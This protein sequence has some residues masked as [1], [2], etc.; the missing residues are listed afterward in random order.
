MNLILLADQDFIA[1]GR[2]R[3][4][5]DRFKQ[6]RDVHGSAVGDT[7]KL[8]LL[9]GL[10]GVGSIENIT[11]EFVELSVEFSERPPEKLPLT[12]ILALPRPKML[13][14]IIRT[15]AEMGVS[16]VIIINSY[17]VEKSYW[18]SPL[19]SPENI[20]TYLIEGLQQSKD[21]VLPKI[22]FERLFKPFVEDDLPALIDGKT[23]F[24]AHPISATA[25]PLAFDKPLALAIGPEGG[26][27]DYE[28]QKLTQVGFESIHLGKRILKVETALPVLIA[29]LFSFSL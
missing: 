29:K 21:T 4:S 28:V 5:G 17:K 6:I 7:V 22:R 14:R 25:C 1:E 19:L 20:E 15:A 11:S 13:R 3:F 9:N 18:Q 24:V 27:T 10:M 16:E 26:F 2:V 23:A 8:G 12:I